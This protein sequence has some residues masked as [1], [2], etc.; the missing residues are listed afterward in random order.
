[1]AKAL[2][3]MTCKKCGK[4]ME[5]PEHCEMNEDGEPEYTCEDCFLKE[6]ENDKTRG[7][8]KEAE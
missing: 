7:S 5:L 6:R 8:S 2:K 3:E 4:I 1:M